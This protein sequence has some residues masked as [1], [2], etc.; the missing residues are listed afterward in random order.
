MPKEFD[1]LLDECL[2]QLKRGARVEELLARY[3]EDADTLRPLLVTMA[4]VYEVRPPVP[5]QAAKAAGRERLMQAVAA[6]Q[7]GVAQQAAV[8]RR[9]LVQMPRPQPS[10]DQRLGAWLSTIFRSTGPVRRMAM[11]VA[12]FVLITG[13]SGYSVSQA[14]AKSLPTSPLYPVKLAQEQLELTLVTSPEDRARLHL[15][16]AN[17]RLDEFNQ[18]VAQGNRVDPQVLAGMQAHTDSAAQFIN[19]LDKNAYLSELV[20]LTKKQEDSLVAAKGRLDSHSQ[21]AVDNTLESV[22]KDK[23]G[24]LNRIQRSGATAAPE[25]PTVI[26]VPP[27]PTSSVTSTNTP[28]PPTATP[29]PPTATSV[30]PTATPV[31]PTATSVPPTATR[32]PPTAT[33]VPP[34][35][36]PVPP[37]ATPVP[38]TSTP[39]PQ[40]QGQNTPIT[41]PPPANT[42]PPTATVPPVQTQPPAQSP[43]STPTPELGGPKLPTPQP[44]ATNTLN[45]SNGQVL[46]PT[47]P[48]PPP[49]SH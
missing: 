2:Y 49:P 41:A 11:V 37:T 43:T 33:P 18:L 6:K 42:P 32:V 15:V 29:V 46:L 17:R 8:A 25:M 44:T 21:E 13:I 36:T 1:A 7:A 31:P 22:R 34:T 5:N 10:W 12:T 4:R 3:P 23:N 26:V 45:G 47:V 40:V 19:G 9:P 27:S 39:T 14:A 30:P 35:V 16:L 38:P 20:D 24:A 48:P 28:V